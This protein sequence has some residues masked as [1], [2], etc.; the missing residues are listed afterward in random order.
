MTK[1]EMVCLKEKNLLPEGS[2]FGNYQKIFVLERLVRFAFVARVVARAAVVLRRSV[3]R[4]FGLV[5]L[6]LLTERPSLRTDF[7][8]DRTFDLSFLSVGIKNGSLCNG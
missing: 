1:N 4:F 2:R 6:L 7:L 8:G 5:A 3:V